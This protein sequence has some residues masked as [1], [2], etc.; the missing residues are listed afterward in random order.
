MCEVLHS[1]FVDFSSS[2]SG[3]YSNLE[4]VL[5][6]ITECSFLRCSA[7]SKGGAI[8][9]A[10]PSTNIS[11][12]SFDSCLSEDEGNSVVISKQS[13]VI[14]CVSTNVENVKI[15]SF[16]FRY[17]NS[18]LKNLNF[19][20]STTYYFPAFWVCYGHTDVSYVICNENSATNGIVVQYQSCSNTCCLHKC[21][22]V[23]NDITISTATHKG[24]FRSCINSVVSLTNSYFKN[25]TIGR[26]QTG[27]NNIITDDT[28]VVNAGT[29]YVDSSP[30]IAAS[31][32]II[33]FTVPISNIGTCRS[34]HQ[35]CSKSDSFLK[36]I[37]LSS[38]IN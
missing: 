17:T 10:G 29:L 16:I 6:D 22:F 28:G 4:T 12:C 37:S 3:I 27:F 33:V 13:E 23:N 7:S 19:S 11:C 34:Y 14:E 31:E 24:I 36:M 26:S 25:N 21:A 5:F 1:K 38:L 32:I 2:N 18:I 8:N 15:A 9:T 30:G 35:T 20:K